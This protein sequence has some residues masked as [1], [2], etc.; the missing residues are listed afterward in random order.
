MIQGSCIHLFILNKSFGQLLDISPKTFIFSKT[1][2]SEC[3]Y[4]EAWVPDQNSK[5]LG[6]ESKINIALV[7]NYSLKYKK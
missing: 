3:S 5:P 7:I 2:D 6:I 1:I 4:F